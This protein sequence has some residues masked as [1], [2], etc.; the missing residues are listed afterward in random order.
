MRVALVH[1]YLR[2]YGGAERVVETLHEIFPDA[3]LY[4]AFY[5]P[6]ALGPQAQRF[7]GWDIRETILKKIPLYKRF[8]SPYRVLA[9][10]AFRQL[11]LSEFDVVISSTNMYM[12]KAVKVKPGA[13]HLSY[14]HTPPRSL[15]G[16]ST[17]TDWRRN[18]LIRI[19]GEIINL[20]M[21]RQDFQTAQNP[22]LLIANGR[23]TQERIKKHY[24]RDSMVVYPPVAL[25]DANLKVLPAQDRTYA[26]FVGRL[27]YSKHPQLALQVCRELDIP[28]KV[29]GTGAL[30][31]SLAAQAGEKVEFLG[32]ADDTALRELYRHAKVVLFPAEDEDFGIVPIEAMAA[33]TPVVAHYSGEPRYT[34]T[35][36]LSG[37]HVK[38]FELDDWKE[39][40]RKAWEHDWDY[41]AIQQSVQEF[42]KANFIEKIKELVV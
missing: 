26:L 34:V 31:D 33:G 5:D 2:E 17:Q 38:S 4:V 10:W 35:G 8:F 11:D 12:A 36:G 42:S 24:R 37:Y 30:A 3:P 9:A 6:A 27:A 41:Q 21:R 1:D 14:I 29:V 13:R 39:T 19:G 18:P 22:D 25:V 15:Y 28:L 20:W 16:L 40:V 23:T 32:S 7:S